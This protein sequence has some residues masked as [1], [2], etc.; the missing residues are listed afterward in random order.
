MS[1]HL[2]C[3][4]ASGVVEQPI[5]LPISRDATLKS[6]EQSVLL[7]PKSQYEAWVEAKLYTTT[8]MKATNNFR[9]NNPEQ[10]EEA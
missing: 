1:I 4:M 7:I 2:V 8:C 3:L 5:E 10:L 6:S 9:P